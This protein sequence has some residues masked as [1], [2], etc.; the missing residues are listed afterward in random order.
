M[1]ERR[2]INRLKKR[3]T[4]RYGT[5]QAT[6]L[7]FTENIS[8][9]GFFIS[10]AVIEPPGSIL[11]VELITPEQEIVK[12]RA[13]VIWAKRVPAQL[14]RRVKGGMGVRIVRFEAGESVYQDMVETKRESVQA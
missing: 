1:A 7:A 6:K 14:L 8:D 2:Y 4:V 9:T 5:D 11:K 10:T 13:R 3:I 12:V